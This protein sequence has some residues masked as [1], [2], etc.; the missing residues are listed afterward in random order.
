MKQFII[1][2]FLCVAFCALV[3]A[4]QRKILLPSRITPKTNP[5]FFASLRMTIVPRRWSAIN[6]ATLALSK[7]PR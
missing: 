1:A 3:N 7:A 5:R 2:I 6:S 4:G